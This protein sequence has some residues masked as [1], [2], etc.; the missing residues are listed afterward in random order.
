MEKRCEQQ[1]AKSSAVVSWS[2]EGADHNQIIT[3]IT[4]FSG[5]YVTIF[6]R[7]C[8]FKCMLLISSDL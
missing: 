5:A 7:R 1:G 2:G 8:Q 6:F 4:L 3:M